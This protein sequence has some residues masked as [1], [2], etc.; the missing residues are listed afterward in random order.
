MNC[1]WSCP[2]RAAQ[3]TAEIPVVCFVGYREE[4]IS[5]NSYSICVPRMSKLWRKLVTQ[6]CSFSGRHSNAFQ[7]QD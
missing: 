7:G 3:C 4:R 2:W 6:S 5:L 1:S